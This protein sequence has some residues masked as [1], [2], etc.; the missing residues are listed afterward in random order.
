M[1]SMKFRGTLAVTLLSSL[2]LA[3]FAVP[4]LVPGVEAAKSGDKKKISKLKKTVKKLKRQLLTQR[5][6]LVPVTTPVPFIEM[7]T[8]GNAG[9]AADSTTYGAVSYEYQIGKYEVTLDQ[10]AAFLNAVAKADASQPTGLYD[11]NMASDMNSAGIARSGSNANYV[12]TVFGGGERPVTYVNWFNAARFCNWLHNGRPTGLQDASTTE[13][14]AYPL[15][16]TTSGVEISRNAGAKYWIPSEDEW[17]KAAYHDPR[18]EG[19][20]GPVGDDNYWLY[21]TASETAP[22]NVIGAE[23]YRANFKDTVFTVTQSASYVGSINYLTAVGAYPG[24]SS[25]HG[26][27]DQGGNVYEWNDTVIVSSRGMRGGSWGF[28]EDDLR[29]SDRLRNA[30]FNEDNDIGF[31]IASP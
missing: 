23:A 5:P 10:Y 29:S 11:T 9:N 12:Y 6:I 14:G 8:V 16:G 25:F 27:F 17:Y 24:S 31:R 21:P 18:S 28:N 30:P 2:L 26:T 4:D 19:E 13:D 7:V 3:T 1:K 15:N 22:G 20:G